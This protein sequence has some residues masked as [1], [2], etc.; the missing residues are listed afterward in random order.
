CGG[1]AESAAGAPSAFFRPRS[2]AQSPATL[3][4]ARRAG[5]EVVVWSADARDWDPDPPAEVAGR[6][7]AGWRPGA[8]LLLHD[9]RADG[10]ADAEGTGSRSDR[11]ATAGLVLAGLTDR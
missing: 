2:G 3:R 7:L 4:A 9:G 6:A 1:V 11:G 10:R 8:I 5:L